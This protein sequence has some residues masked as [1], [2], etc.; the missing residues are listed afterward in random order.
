MII[1]KVRARGFGLFESLELELPEHLCVVHGANETGKSTLAEAIFAALY[2]AKELK[3]TRL[4]ERSEVSRLRPWGGGDFTVAVDVLLATGQRLAVVRRLGSRKDDLSV[5]DLATGEDLNRRGQRAAVALDL[6]AGVSADLFRASVLISDL[7]I[8]AI[9]TQALHERTSNL[10]T[11][12]DETVSVRRAVELIEKQL[13]EVGKSDQPGQTKI[14]QAIASRNQLESQIADLN[15]LRRSTLLD[16]AA[17][18]SAAQSA[19]AELKALTEARRQQAAIRRWVATER[20]GE[21]AANRAKIEGLEQELKPLAALAQID[22]QA[23]DGLRATIAAAKSAAGQEQERAQALRQQAAEERKAP[24]A[25]PEWVDRAW[26]ELN[27][28]KPS[29]SASGAWWPWLA[30]IV[31]V[32]AAAGLFASG[33]PAGGAAALMAAVA[34]AAWTR[35]T[36]PKTTSVSSPRSTLAAE[37]GESELTVELVRRV[38]AAWAT[39]RREQEIRD[40]WMAEADR[41]EASAQ[42]RL[43]QAQRT[44]ADLARL[45]GGL[46]EGTDGQEMEQKLHLLAELQEELTAA[47]EAQ[48]RLMD[49]PESTLAAWQAGAETAVPGD[50]RGQDLEVQRLEEALRANEVKSQTLAEALSRRLGEHSDLPELEAAFRRADAQVVRRQRERNALFLAQQI[51]N[52]VGAEF[53]R[54]MGPELAKRMGGWLERLSDGRYNQAT[55]QDGGAPR[56]TGPG[57]IDLRSPDQLSQGTQDLVYLSLRLALCELVFPAETMPLIVDEPS[58]H[59]DP[60]RHAR[61]IAALAEISAHRQ[62]VV[63]TCHPWERDALAAAGAGVLEPTADAGVKIR[64]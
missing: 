19:A 26:Q 41:L 47:R 16:Q 50:L 21:L 31:L 58:A 11:S 25:S 32:A 51:L 33:Q 20:L 59:L 35:R 23:A 48:R 22:P 52:E 1:E 43:D 45:V 8:R 30:A 36:R 9:D 18:E 29:P 46:P 12:G 17:Q 6:L 24:P 10:S 5:T 64:R 40:A 60:D 7:P 38:E 61:L 27:R 39:S 57:E 4:Q 55:L 62:V 14:G 13:G 15:E 37:A 28:P 34:L 53:H 54:E 44:E 3:G 49:P 2:G 63:L 56:I 42:A